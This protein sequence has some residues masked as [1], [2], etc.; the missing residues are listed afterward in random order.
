MHQLSHLLRHRRRARLTAA[1]VLCTS[2]ALILGGCSS[3]D[4]SSDSANTT[5]APT[6]DASGNGSGDPEPSAT[7]VDPCSLLTVGDLQAATGIDFGEGTINDTMTNDASAV[8]DWTSSGD[9]FATAQVIVVQGGAEN[10]DSQRDSANEVSATSD[11]EVTGADSAYRT[12]EGSIVGMAIGDDFVQVS[13]IPSGPGDVGDATL[14][15]AETA[16]ANYGS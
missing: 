10:L 9:E 7:S 8:C 3:E 11:V 1:L 15:L 6:G 13:Y 2:V 12:E 5:T 4:D 16:A 14:Q